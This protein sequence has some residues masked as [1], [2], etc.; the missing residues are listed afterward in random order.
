MRFGVCCSAKDAHLV[1][2]E[3]YDYVELNFSHITA[4]N[5]EDFNAVKATLEKIGIQAESYNGFFPWT[6]KLYTDYT[7]DTLRKYCEIGFSRAQTLGGKIAV[8][9]CGGPRRIPEGADPEATK[10]HF[11]RFARIIGDVADKYDITV[12]I[13]PLNW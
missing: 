1:K 10:E 12:A 8:L 13:E 9:G 11:V 2:Q 7:D 6:Q 3:G 5:E 4:M